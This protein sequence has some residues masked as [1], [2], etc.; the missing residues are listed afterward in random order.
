[1]G[2]LGLGRGMVGVDVGAKLLWRNFVGGL[3]KVFDSARVYF[4]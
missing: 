1:M 3:R 2:L 4:M